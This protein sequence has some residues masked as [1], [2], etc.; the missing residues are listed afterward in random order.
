[1]RIFFS[2]LL[3]AALTACAGGRFN[4]RST[5]LVEASE[6]DTDIA[7]L[8]IEK[9]IPNRYPYQEERYFLETRIDKR[10]GAVRHTL[11]VQDV[12]QGMRRTYDGAAD[13]TA[14]SLP[15]DPLYRSTAYNRKI[16]LELVGV[17]L[18]E[19]TLR[20]RRAVGYRVRLSSKIGHQEILPIPPEQIAAQLDT[21]DK[22]KRR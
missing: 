13:D 17:E 8:G 11:V 1:M 19:A 20:E 18:D 12:Y 22:I 15:V 16:K 21:L 2:L 4:L 9:A 5:A 6:F 14:R 10:S 3:V 7:I